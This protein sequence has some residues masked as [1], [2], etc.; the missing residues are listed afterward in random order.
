MT[1][2]ARCDAAAAPGGP[3]LVF[4]WAVLAEDEKR[5]DGAAGARGA[6]EGVLS[7]SAAAAGAPTPVPGAVSSAGCGLGEA[8]VAAL[9]P[10]Y[11]RLYVWVGSGRAFATANL[12]LLVT[13]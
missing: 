13:A 4:S 5:I 2:R 11:Y 8:A 10:G 3:A 6:G 9:T 7:Q 1:A 12:P